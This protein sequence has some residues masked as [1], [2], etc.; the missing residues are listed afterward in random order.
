MLS[1]LR[2]RTGMGAGQETIEG[3]QK[4]VRQALK[5][6]D[7][8]MMRLGTHVTRAVVSG[9]AAALNGNQNRECQPEMVRK[10]VAEMSTKALSQN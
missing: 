10:W 2:C 7:V 5:F 6:C 4:A 1:L 9:H 3:I 8:P